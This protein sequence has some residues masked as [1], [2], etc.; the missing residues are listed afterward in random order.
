MLVYDGDS[1]KGFFANSDSDHASDPD[2]RRSQ[3]GYILK[4]AKGLVS[5]S[6][7][8]QKTVALSSTK[9]EYMALS[10]CCRQVRWIINLLGEIG[11]PLFGFPL[12]GD[13]MGSIFM[14]NNQAQDRRTKHI[15]VRYH[16][17]RE[18]TESGLVSVYYIPTDQNV[19]DLLTKNLAWV[20]FKRFRDQLGLEFKAFR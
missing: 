20:K 13:N 5:W 7:Y 16:H 12:L 4:L 17:I 6:F 2:S 19:A 8:L 3:T 14:S 10:D 9:A 18:V 1:G 11:F 15:D